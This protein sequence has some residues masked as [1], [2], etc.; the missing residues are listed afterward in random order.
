M[1]TCIQEYML[2]WNWNERPNRANQPS[3]YVMCM[4]FHMINNSKQS[5]YQRLKRAH[6]VQLTEYREANQQSNDCVDAVN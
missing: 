1:H 6:K 3:V 5:T 2:N 4:K